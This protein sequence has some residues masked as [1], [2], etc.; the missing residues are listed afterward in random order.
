VRSLSGRAAALRDVLDDSLGDL[1]ADRPGLGAALWSELRAAGELD[2]YL[3]T[4]RAIETGATTAAS[5]GVGPTIRARH[6][7]ETEIAHGHGFPSFDA[8]RASRRWKLLGEEIDHVRAKTT[9]AKA[10]RAQA[11]RRRSDV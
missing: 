10:W 8:L 6:L 2:A 5:T 4:M 11:F 9:A 1:L 7:A 3:M